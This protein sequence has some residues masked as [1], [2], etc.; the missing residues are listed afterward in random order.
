MVLRNIKFRVDRING[1]SMI[2]VKDVIDLLLMIP[3]LIG[4]GFGV[5]TIIGDMIQKLEELDKE[6][7]GY[8]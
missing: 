6:S 2:A 4:S 3:R 7:G 5:V 8:D 1:V